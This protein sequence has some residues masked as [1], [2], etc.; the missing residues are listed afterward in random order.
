MDMSEYQYKAAQTAIYPKDKGI[1]YVALGLVNEAG[2]FAGK[3]KKII[4]D[5]PDAITHDALV[6]ELG[7]TLWYLAQA[8]TELSIDLSAVARGNVE[9]LASRA[10]RGVIGGAGDDR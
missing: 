7:D 6:A 3:V 2:E 1:E 4:R 10:E 5:G 9:K 8:A